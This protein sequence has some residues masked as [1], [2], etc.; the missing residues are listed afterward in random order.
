MSLDHTRFGRLLGG[1]TGIALLL[2]AGMIFSRPPA[3]PLASAVVTAREAKQ[4]PADWGT[5]HTYYQGETYG[6]QDL[7]NGVAVIKPGRE[8]HPPHQH[9]EEEF[10]M[11][12]EGR[13]E[14]HVNGKTFAAQAGD[15]LYAAPWDVHGIKNTGDTVLKF[16]VWKWNNKGV[17]PPARPA[18]G[19]K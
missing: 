15:I 13:G 9:A 11:V 14:W 19:N 2:C 12:T 8:I 10:L 6:T 4:E 7:L 16:V 1:L 3:K 17:A 18:E 5:F